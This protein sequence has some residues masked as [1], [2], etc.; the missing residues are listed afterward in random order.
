MVTNLNHRDVD[1][2]RIAAQFPV[3]HSLVSCFPLLTGISR[4]VHIP[5]PPVSMA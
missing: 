4:L 1:F 3:R 2:C 5:H